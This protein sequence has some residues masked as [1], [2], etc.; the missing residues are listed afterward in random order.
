MLLEE[1]GGSSAAL[2]SPTPPKT[3]QATTPLSPMAA[4]H[5]PIQLAAISNYKLAQLTFAPP[6]LHSLRK[7]AVIK[8]VLELI[9]NDTPA[10]WLDQMTRWEFFTPES[11][12]N[13]TQEGLEEMFS[14]YVQTMEA[15]QPIKS[16]EDDDDEEQDG[17]ETMWE[18]EIPTPDG[19]PAE[20]IFA[21][22]TASFS[23]DSIV[24]GSML[25]DKPLPEK[26]DDKQVRRK[27]VARNRLSW[28][29]DTGV[30]SSAVTQH[31]ANEL[32]NLFDMEFSVDIDLN[33]APRLPELAFSKRDQQQRRQSQRYS[34]DSFMGLIPAFETFR[35]EEELRSAGSRKMTFPPPPSKPPPEDALKPN[36]RRSTSLPITV[37]KPQRKPPQR[38]SS[39]KYRQH[40]QQQQ[41][42]QTQAQDREVIRSPETEREPE[43]ESKKNHEFFSGLANALSR[44]GPK[45]SKK[46]SFRRLASLVRRPAPS[47]DLL[48]VQQDDRVVSRES[49][50]ST[51]SSSSWSS[52]EVPQVARAIPL[53]SLQKPLPE[54][55]SSLKR[56]SFVMARPVLVDAQ[57]LRRA[58][59]LGHRTNQ[60][61]KRQSLMESASK[62]RSLILQEQPT[63]ESKKVPLSRSRSALIKIGSGARRSLRRAASSKDRCNRQAGWDTEDSQSEQASGG[64]FVKRMA[65]IGKR[66]KLQRA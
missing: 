60:R 20:S 27:S 58:R 54:T 13:M 46:K 49:I 51:A 12:S 65:S 6:N 37:E 43:T 9:Y 31:L 66:M 25:E 62:R 21:H 1:D 10:E 2:H 36:R 7:T 11:L 30:P 40:S 34:N 35:L 29:S 28:T 41:Q 19:T 45:L 50:N 5:N 32:M 52:V 64:Y 23:S 47:T 18:D 22:P 55:P 4:V 14:Q 24:R 59:S 48:T 42:Q 44:D 56:R 63:V 57:E 38:S 17:G 53:S 33:T 15:F 3:S 16:M 39:L 26:P 61:K 8:N